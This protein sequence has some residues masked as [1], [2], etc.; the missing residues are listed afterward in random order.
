MDEATVFVVDDDAE[1]RKSLQWLLESVNLN[2]VAYGCAQAF[3][4]GYDSRRPGCLVLDVR[5]PGVSGLELQERLQARGINIPVIIITAHADVPT[6]VRAMKAGAIDFLEKPFS[7]QLL[8]DR[9]QQALARDRQTRDEQ[10]RRAGVG[11]RIDS[12][13]S[14]ERQVMDLVVQG[15]V[16]KQ[17]AAELGLSQKTVEHYRARI[18]TKMQADGLAELV[19]LVMFASGKTAL[20]AR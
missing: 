11:S 15:R 9:I 18:M 2:A 7:G 13:T 12:L 5:M 6:A 10:A 19:R 14:R 8:L 4:D 3:L 20:P 16:N 17:I 1:M